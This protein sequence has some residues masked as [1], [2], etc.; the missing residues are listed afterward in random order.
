[1]AFN[2]NFNFE[3]PVT[4]VAAGFYPSDVQI[5]AFVGEHAEHTHMWTVILQGYVRYWAAASEPITNGVSNTVSSIKVFVTDK[6]SVDINNLAA[7]YE[8]DVHY[9]ADNENR[10]SVLASI[11]DSVSGNVVH[12]NKM[13]FKVKNITGPGPLPIGI[14]LDNMQFQTTVNLVGSTEVVIVDPI[15]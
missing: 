10:V 11:I 9:I 15:Y 6:I 12:P 3:T 13:R 14:E 4:R 8:T 2:R 5:W 1:M 7:H